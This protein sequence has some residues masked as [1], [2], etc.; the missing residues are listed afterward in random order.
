MGEQPPFAGLGKLYFCRVEDLDKQPV[1]LGE[2][3][4][5]KPGMLTYKDDEPSDETKGF[6]GTFT[7]TMAEPSREMVEL[8]NRPALWDVKLERKPGRM[9]RKMKKAYRSDYRRNTKWTRKVANYLRRMSMTFH[10]AEIVI[11][12][13]QHDRLAA[14]IEATIRP[15][16]A[17]LNNF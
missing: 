14:Q 10:N 12:K 6:S 4:P 3:I 16:A 2:A 5:I 7:G 11:T 1:P 13:E 9:P 8:L 15:A 17:R